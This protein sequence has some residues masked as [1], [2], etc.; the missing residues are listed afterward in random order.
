MAE[1]ASVRHCPTLSDTRPTHRRFVEFRRHRRL[2]VEAPMPIHSRSR[3]SPQFG[4]YKKASNQR[5]NAQ[6]WRT[7]GVRAGGRWVIGRL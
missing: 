4:G 7:S 6:T 3:T 2:N 1:S 5:E